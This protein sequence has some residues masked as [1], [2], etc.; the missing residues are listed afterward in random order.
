MSTTWSAGRRLL[1]VAP[2]ESPMAATTAADLAAV[3]GALRQILMRHAAA[4]QIQR[5]DDQQLYLDTHHR[6]PNK[7]PLFFGAVQRKK[8]TVAFHLMPVYLQPELLASISPAL[9]VRMQGQSC[10]HFKHLEPEL[11][12]ELAAL[13]QAGFDS[14][15]AAGYV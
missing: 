9:K 14:Y 3:D 10:F 13:T 5:D 6:Q 1:A 15:V 12:A 7:K 8:A 4:L 11:L 2:D